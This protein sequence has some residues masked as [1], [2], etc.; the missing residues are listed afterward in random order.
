MGLRPTMPRAPDF[1]GVPGPLSTLLAPL[2]ALYGLGATLRRKASRPWRAPVPVVC[3]GNLVV[4]GGGKTP[5]AIALAEFLID[6]GRLPHFLTRG[7]GGREAGPL[8]VDTSRHGAAEVGDEALLLARVA[9][10]WVARDRAAGARDAIAA[11]ADILVMD[12]GFQ[13]GALVHDVALLVVDGSYGFGNGRVMPAGPLR[14]PLEPGI[15]R[16]DAMIVVG[17][18]STGISRWAARRLT[19]FG[20]R[21][22]PV[23]GARDIA[24]ERVFAFAGIARPEKFYR[25]LRSMGCTVVGTRDFPDHHPFADAEIAA[26]CADADDADAIAVTTEKDH[27]RLPPGARAAIRALPVTLVWAEPDTPDRLLARVLDDG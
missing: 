5:V 13:N 22:V 12:D 18:D 19:V 2:G 11:G 10:T 27:V 23:A 15:A 1:W 21:T 24:G 20:A 9:P 26:I 3:V 17:E 7:Y 25:T 16:A 4:G 8:R 6:K 14:E